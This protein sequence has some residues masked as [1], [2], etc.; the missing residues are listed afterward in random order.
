M[1]FWESFKS[2]VSLDADLGDA[3]ALGARLDAPLFGA[4]ASSDSGGAPPTDAL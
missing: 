2:A 3:A 4:G 1:S